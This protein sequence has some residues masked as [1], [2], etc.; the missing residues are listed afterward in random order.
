MQLPDRIQLSTVFVGRPGG[1][2][3]DH[4]ASS[5]RGFVAMYIGVSITLYAE[6][7]PAKLRTR[8]SMA[9][10]VSTA[11]FAGLHRFTPSC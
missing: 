4:C 7:F 6:L 3:G 5:A 9:Y 11:I 1:W 8:I 2:L 10:N